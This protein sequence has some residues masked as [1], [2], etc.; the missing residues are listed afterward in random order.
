MW[1]AFK[2]SLRIIAIKACYIGIL[3]RVRRHYLI[4]NLILGFSL[5]RPNITW[6]N[7]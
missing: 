4:F 2:V 3:H 7:L 6:R 1:K 5:S